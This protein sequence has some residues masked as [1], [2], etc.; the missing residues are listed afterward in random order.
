VDAPAPPGLVK[1][2]H[3]KVS[4]GGIDKNFTNISG[5]I[6]YRAGKGFGWL[7]P[8]A[9][10]GS[11][12]DLRKPPNAVDTKGKS[13]FIDGWTV[14]GVTS[15]NDNNAGAARTLAGNVISANLPGNGN[16]SSSK[17]A[18]GS[19]LALNAA[20]LTKTMFEAM[21]GEKELINGVPK[22]E[23]GVGGM[24]AVLKGPGPRTPG[25]LPMF[26]L[27]GTVV[28]EKDGNPAINFDYQGQRLFSTSIP[29]I[30]KATSQVME[31]L[32][33]IPGMKELLEPTP[34]IAPGLGV[35]PVRTGA[36][37]GAS[38][39]KPKP[40]PKIGGDTVTQSVQKMPGYKP[41]Q[42]EKISIN[43][44]GQRFNNVPLLP[45]TS[46]PTARQ[47]ASS[48]AELINNVNLGKYSGSRAD[49]DLAYQMSMRL[50][51]GHQRDY[52]QAKLMSD[53]MSGATKTVTGI[54]QSALKGD[55]LSVSKRN[56]I[57]DVN[58]L[59]TFTNRLRVKV[60]APA[61]TI[62][63]LAQWANYAQSGQLP[64]AR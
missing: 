12:V 5:G 40:Q 64:K 38:K 26:R 27:F 18:A 11:I 47:P 2:A 46:A 41:T 60:G 57:I 45:G 7:D 24:M 51:A 33:R 43:V 56:T 28:A 59:L 32:K 50:P 54:I 49:T 1:I 63:N 36:S 37:S 14:L 6:S 8:A 42:T 39:P 48:A 53:Y 15:P 34:R 44:N 61:W 29:E 35:V 55:P 19:T 13:M 31:A 4:A 25:L 17:A 20:S 23:V 10:N 62:P 30:Q 22:T 58:N 3:G 9:L 52:L 21:N 16:S